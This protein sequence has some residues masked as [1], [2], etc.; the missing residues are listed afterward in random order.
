MKKRNIILIHALYWFYI[1]NQSLFPMYI[2]KLE[3]AAWVGNRYLADVAVS[4]LMNIVYFYTI[5]FSFPKI[6][7]IRNKILLF[8]CAV[9][10]IFTIVAVTLPLELG[11]WKYIWHAPEKEL[12]FQ[13][14]WVWN[15]LRMVI[16]I[17]IY[18]ILIRY[19]INAI[20]GQ[21]LRDELIN[22]RQAGEL[23]LLKSQVN[24]HFL[25]NTL[26]NIYS[27]VY[28][29]S[30][31]APEAVMKFSLIMRYVL[32]DAN[33]ESVHLEQETEYIRSYIELQKLRIKQPGFVE[34]HVEGSTDT[35]IAP[36][37]L[38]PFIENA[39]KHGSRN[40]QPGIVIHLHAENNLIRFEISNFFRKHPQITEKQS[41]GIGLPNIRRRLELIY[42]GR[43]ELTI[44]EENDQF[45]VI[46]IIKNQ[47]KPQEMN[48]PV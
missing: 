45:K 47:D 40:H 19:L 27:L 14:V 36:M 5:Y 16:I 46:L 31:E 9:F 20:E 2:G 28:H 41:G 10:L 43:H 23:A 6:V 34:L 12:I 30:E 38:I 26:N 24:P 42:P 29:K 48:Y 21:K 7:A 15:T 44:R 1:I 35:M 37:L 3:E 11:F 25:F 22:Q 17:G 13:W 32:H 4:I 18:A 39:F 8:A 33:A